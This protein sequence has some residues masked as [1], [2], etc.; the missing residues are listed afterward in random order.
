MFPNFQIARVEK[1]IIFGKDNKDKKQSS[2]HSIEKKSADICRWTSFVSQSSQFSS[3]ENCSLL[4]TVDVRGQIYDHRY[5]AKWKLLFIYKEAAN[6]C[7]NNNK[8][9]NRNVYFTPDL[10]I[11]YYNIIN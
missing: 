7:S 2:L 9:I 3:K 11:T 4:E 5:R 1:K 8:Q 6:K 10:Q